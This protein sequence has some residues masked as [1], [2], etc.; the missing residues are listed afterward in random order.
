MITLDG[1][2]A[3]EFYLARAAD[4]QRAAR[5]VRLTRRAA[6]AARQRK[7][8]GDRRFWRARV[9]QTTIRATPG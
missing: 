8:S 5:Q 6:A 3:H 4:L 1:Y 7:P 2:F 9:R